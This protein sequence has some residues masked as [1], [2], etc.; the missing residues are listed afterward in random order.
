MLTS[1]RGL[2]SDQVTE[3]RTASK[4]PPR[5]ER[6]SAGDLHRRGLWS[7]QVTW[8]LEFPPKGGTGRSIARP[9]GAQSGEHKTCQRTHRDQ[10]NNT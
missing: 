7:D 10:R 3:R 2:W 1:G 4:V 9:M 6:S 8:L 5:L